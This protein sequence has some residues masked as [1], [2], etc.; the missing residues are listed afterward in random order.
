MLLTYFIRNKHKSVF[1]SPCSLL[2]C[3]KIEYKF[4]EYP[5][6]QLYDDDELSLSRNYVAKGAIKKTDLRKLVT[7]H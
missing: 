5:F 6:G 1:S 4:E 2:Q 7:Y 3:R